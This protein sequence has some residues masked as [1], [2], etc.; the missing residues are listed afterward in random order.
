MSVIDDGGLLL[1][2][3]PS[4]ASSMF[5]RG[6]GF[7]EQ[8]SRTNVARTFFA[9]HGVSGEIVLDPADAPSGIEPRIRL[10]VYVAPPDQVATEDADLTIRVVG[11][12]EIDAW[13]DLAIDANEPM[14]D[15]AV[16]WRSMAPHVGRTPD[17]VL[18]AGEAD[19]RIVAAA[20]LF[21]TDGVGWQS[22]ASVTPSA[23]GN[24]YQ[25]A[26]IAARAKLAAEAGCELVAAWALVDAHSSRN[27]ARAGLRRIGQRVVVAASALG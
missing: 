23:R 10:D 11:D 6:L 4:I 8:P 9:E 13:M 21:V 25:R 22:W 1:G 15:V 2:A 5:N 26:L 17:W 7:T 3:A 27:L 19:G 16:L 18:V 12:S 24:G 14:P 20:S